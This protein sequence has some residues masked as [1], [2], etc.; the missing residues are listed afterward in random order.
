MQEDHPEWKIII[1][2][3]PLEKE[4]QKYQDLKGLKGIEIHGNKADLSTLLV[5]SRIQISVYST[6][7][8]DALGLDVVNMSLQGYTSFADYAAEMVK[9][10]IA[11]PLRTDED[12]VALLNSKAQMKLSRGQ[13]YAPF[14]EN[15]AKGLLTNI[16]HN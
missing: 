11:I 15:R 3:H 14:D 2:T 1:K 6:T 12:P 4:V 13:V 10:G 8:F 5:R 9:E 16:A 7:F